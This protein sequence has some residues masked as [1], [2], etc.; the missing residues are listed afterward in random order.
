MAQ[1]NKIDKKKVIY[2]FLVI[3]LLILALFLSYKTIFSNITY[4]NFILSTFRLNGL[5]Y[6]VFVLLLFSFIRS[7]FYSTLLWYTIKKTLNKNKLSFINFILLGMQ[8]TFI[9]II[10]PFATGS[11]PYSIAYLKRKGFQIS[12]IL[13]ITIFVDLV[14]QIVLVLLPLILSPYSFIISNINWSDKDHILFVTFLIIGISLDLLIGLFLLFTGVSYR[15][16]KFSIKITY[17][18]YV[19]ILRK[20]DGDKKKE[21]WEKKQISFR[22]LCLNCIKNYKIF[23][24]NLTIAFLGLF[25]ISIMYYFSCIIGSSNTVKLD[26]FQVVG[27][28]SAS[29]SA[30]GMI[31]L[32]GGLGSQEWLFSVASEDFFTNKEHISL[33][34]LVWRFWTSFIPGFL[35]LLILL[36]DV[37]FLIFKNKKW[38]ND[39]L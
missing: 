29:F 39:M 25:S 13:P 24:I 19:Q 11:Q 21:A 18:F 28:S 14:Y 22:L 33:S 12:E 34:I 8:L 9:Q 27:L 3:S 35:G 26:F 2:I 17:W 31:P 38:N 5:W 4:D 37:W 32:P 6:F 36:I 15:F 10:T 7:I 16:Q 20:S 23:F 1:K 30:N